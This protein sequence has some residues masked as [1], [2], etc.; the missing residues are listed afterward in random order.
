MK[1]HLK[2]TTSTNAWLTEKVREMRAAGN[3][4]PDLYAVYADFQTAG[5]GA[6][7]NTWHSSRGL[8]ILTSI[9]FDSG[10]AAADQFVFNLWFATSTRLFLSKYVPEV[11]IK[12]PNDMYVHDRKLAGDL[13]EHSVSGG[14]L[15]F[16]VAGIGINVNEERFPETI[17][18]PT[19]LYLETGQHYDID[20]LMDEYLSLLRERRPLLCTDHAT[21]LREEYLSHLYR[22]NEPHPYIIHGQQITGIIRDIDRFGRL[23]LEL[24]DGKQEAYGFKEVGYCINA[25]L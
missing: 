17:P 19:S 25:E 5:R 8:N 16:T 22:L 12:W 20:T 23:V 2:E 10:L 13:T 18:H 4:V 15:D 6:G 24:P 3:P 7:S 1:H 14:R 9:C 21:E 11:L